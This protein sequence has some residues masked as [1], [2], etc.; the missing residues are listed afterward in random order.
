MNSNVILIVLGEPNSTFSEILFKYFKSNDFKKNKNKIILVGNKKLFEKQ[1]KLLNYNFYVNE[2]KDIDDA[3]LN[4]NLFV[5]EKS[6]LNNDV[7]MNSRLFVSDD[8]SLNNNLFVQEKSI[9]N[10]DVSMNSNLF[11]GKDVSM[12][13][14]LFVANDLTIG[15]STT[16]IGSMGSK[17]TVYK[18]IYK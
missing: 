13:S 12:N 15:G 8:V 18:T 17:T 14:K 7:I 10:N 3:S 4:K 2:V 6:T 5:Q 9:L 1:M 16:G 11:V